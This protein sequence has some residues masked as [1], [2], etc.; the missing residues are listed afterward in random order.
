[1]APHSHSQ[2][3]EK[4]DKPASV[5]DSVLSVAQVKKMLRFHTSKGYL[6]NLGEPHNQWVAGNYI[7]A[8]IKAYFQVEKAEN[9]NK[10]KDPPHNS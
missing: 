8:S 6:V 5:V 1:M 7:P 3:C 10:L 2:Y 4:H 9:K